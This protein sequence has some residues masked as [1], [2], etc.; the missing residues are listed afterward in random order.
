L[1]LNFTFQRKPHAI[2]FE[3]GTANSAAGAFPVR[4]ELSQKTN[5]ESDAF[6]YQQAIRAE[7]RSGEFFAHTTAAQ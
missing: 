7:V 1:Q 2:I 4:A 5:S 6:Y 3:I